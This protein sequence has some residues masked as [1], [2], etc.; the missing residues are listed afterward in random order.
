MLEVLFTSSTAIYSYI[1]AEESFAAKFPV[2]DLP[3][4]DSSNKK[5]N[6]YILRVRSILST[7]LRYVKNLNTVDWLCLAQDVV[8]DLLLND[9]NLIISPLYLVLFST[10][11]GISGHA[12]YDQTSDRGTVVRATFFVSRKTNSRRNSCSL[13]RCSSPPIFRW[14]LFRIGPMIAL[15][16]KSTTQQ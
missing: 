12:K 11:L 15:F 3:N 14:S 6:I 5:L 4:R 10:Q 8:A 13:K 9:Q 16:Q 7:S 1:N 2:L